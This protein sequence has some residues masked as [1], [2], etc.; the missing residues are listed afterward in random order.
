MK[1]KSCCYNYQDVA[2]IK[3]SYESQQ[4]HG[5][6][7]SEQKAYTKSLA[8]PQIT[9]ALYCAYKNEEMLTQ[10]CRSSANLHGLMC[11]YLEKK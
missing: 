11:E 8:R 9:Y 5:N 3:I 1:S 6:K 7:D 4:L 10:L 2:Q